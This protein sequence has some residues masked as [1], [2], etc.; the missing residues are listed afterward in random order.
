LL[1]AQAWLGAHIAAIKA[2]ESGV[3]AKSRNRV[4][5]A[6]AKADAISDPGEPPVAAEPAHSPEDLSVTPLHLA[7]VASPVSPA[8]TE[9]VFPLPRSALP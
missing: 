9:Q 7:T 2:I 8:S 4:E 6:I 1:Q 3:T 5:A